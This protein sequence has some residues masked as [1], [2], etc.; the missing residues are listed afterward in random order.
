MAGAGGG[1]SP[2]LRSPRVVGHAMSTEQD[3]GLVLTA[4]AQAIKSRGD[5][6][7]VVV[8]SDRGGIYGAGEYIGK[9]RE[10]GL[11]RSMS[12]SGNPWDNAV[13]ESFFS[14]LTHERLN[15]ERYGHSRWARQPRVPGVV[16]D[17]LRSS[18]WLARVHRMRSWSRPAAPTHNSSRTICRR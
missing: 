6:R 13:V 9:A 4:L 2:L 1:S 8:H 3:G 15:R 16:L 7:N 12:R 10:H 18:A 11:R 5:P 17:A 14:T